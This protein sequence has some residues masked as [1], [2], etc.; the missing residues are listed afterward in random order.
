[1]RKTLLRLGALLVIVLLIVCVAG[2]VQE[3]Y[4]IHVGDDVFV[5]AEEEVG[6]ALSVGGSVH[7]EGSVLEDVLAIGGSVFLGPSSVVHGDVTS[8]GG[9]VV[10]QEGSQVL[11]EIRSLDPYLIT[12]IFRDAS[13]SEWS[14]DRDLPFIP[15]LYRFL[16][17]LALALIM[18]ALIPEK[19]G[20]ISS[21]ITSRTGE[22][23][24][25]GALGTLLIFPVA[26][27]LV[28]S[29]VGIILIPIEL[30]IVAVSAFLGYV[31]VV[32]LV[33]GRIFRALGKETSPLVLET[34]L[35]SAVLWAAGLVPYARWVVIGAVWVMGL[36]GFITAVIHRRSIRGGPL[37]HR[38]P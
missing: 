32:A 36:G 3:E 20:F 23:L 5:A 16:G 1:M 28:I 2:C 27:I 14:K 8:V 11:G 6:S 21:A 25:W 19:I 31:A 9:M 13:P 10:K 12:S 24:F 29:L 7:V 26:L 34:L 18:V 33:G 37:M 15:G 22:S 38:V 4:R 35:G 30:A 17:F